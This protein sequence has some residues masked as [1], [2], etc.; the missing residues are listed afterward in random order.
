VRQLVTS[1]LLL[2]SEKQKT[3]ECSVVAARIGFHQKTK[4]FTLLLSIKE[5]SPKRNWFS[6]KRKRLVMWSPGDMEVATLLPFNANILFFNF[7]RRNIV[8][9]LTLFR[10]GSWMYDQGFGYIRLQR[11]Q[12]VN[13]N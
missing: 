12:G 11:L 8:E 7:V 3:C 2:L 10:A 1:I 4:M 5:S 9:F 13:A 6:S